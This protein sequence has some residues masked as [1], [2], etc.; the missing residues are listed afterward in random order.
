M[1][2][3]AVVLFQRADS[4]QGKSDAQLAEAQTAASGL[5]RDARGRGGCG[6]PRH[7]ADAG[8]AAAIASGDDARIDARLRTLGTRTRAVRVELV[9]VDGDDVRGYVGEGIAVA[10]AT[11]QLVAQGNAPAGQL[12][13]STE[14]AEG[15]AT[16]LQAITGMQ[17]LVIGA[18][19]KTLAATLG[20]VDPAALPARGETM[21]GDRRY[22][23]TPML[24]TP[25]WDP[26]E[27]LDVRLLEDAHATRSG[28]TGGSLAI[29]VGCWSASCCSRSCSPS[30]SPARCRPRS[31][32]LHAARAARQRRPPREGAD[33]RQR[34]VRRARH[35]VQ[36][37]GAPARAAADRARERARNG[38]THAIRRVGESFAKNLDRDALLEIV[39]Q[40]AVDG[41]AASVGRATV[42]ASRARSADRGR[43]RAGE[44][45]GLRAGAGRGRGRGARGRPGRRGP[46]A[47]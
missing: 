9:L 26:Q 7:R 44:H 47:S 19:G 41:V 29:A 32:R 35:G 4:E 12:K 28:L 10:P 13:V 38:C 45:D 1:I 17:A 39:V 3:V 30:P 24:T 2:A 25:A 6:R 36:R 37:D 11:T 46:A 43:A 33:G 8:L 18:D 31:T 34:R 15:L 20:G 27:R 5:Y 40:T 42:R 16:R 23:V 22:R 14:T 21:V